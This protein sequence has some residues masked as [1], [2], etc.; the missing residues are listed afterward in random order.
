VFI[1][2]TGES[3]KNTELMEMPFEGQ[4]RLGPRNYDALDGGCTLVPPGT[5]SG[6]ICAAV[7]MLP[8]ATITVATGYHLPPPPPLV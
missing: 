7:V 6:L 5:F 2:Q 4:T 8:V 3:Y 1:G